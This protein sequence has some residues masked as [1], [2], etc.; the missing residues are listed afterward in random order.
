MAD[1]IQD[2]IS[3]FTD[4][5]LTPEECEF[6]V[7]RLERDPGSREK[8]LRYAV[9]GAALR[10][11]LVGPDPDVLRNRLRQTLEGVSLAPRTATDSP[12]WA[13][14]VIRPVLGTGIAAGVAA[15]GLL[16]LNN[17]SQIGPGGGVPVI[18]AQQ[19][20]AGGP[21]SQ[22]LSYVVPQDDGTA[23]GTAERSIQPQLLLT[24][25]LVRH[26]EYAFGIGRRSIDSYVVSGQDIWR[27]ADTVPTE[28]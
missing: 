23:L 16:A 22:A 8:V 19:A 2:Q 14:R 11:E 18:V 25:Y 9:I 1:Q 20:T 13:T 26:G 15:L 27:V 21:T 4:D 24:N 5:E 12:G 28:E 7:R 10:G 17:D 6:L 3:A